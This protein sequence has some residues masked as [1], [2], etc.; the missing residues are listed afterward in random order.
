MVPACD[1]ASPSA[2]PLT[3]LPVMLPLIV[4]LVMIMPP[5]LAMPPP[6]IA[7]RIAADR[8]VGDGQGAGAAVEDPATEVGVANLP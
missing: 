8:R 5:K 6:T 2:V 3:G 1:A 7:G 4:E